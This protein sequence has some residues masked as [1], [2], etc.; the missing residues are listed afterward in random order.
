MKKVFKNALIFAGS[1]LSLPVD[2]VGKR[3]VGIIVPAGWASASMTFSVA[4]AEGP[5][6]YDMYDQ[7]GIEFSVSPVAGKFMP[8]GLQLTYDS[9]SDSPFSNIEKIRI[10]SGTAEAPVNQ[11][12]EQIIGLVLR[13]TN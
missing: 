5:I 6:F 7:A 10:R 8:L 3:L 13:E 9:D 12:S 2:I 1:A 11:T 4:P